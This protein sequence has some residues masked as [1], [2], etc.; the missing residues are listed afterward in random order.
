[1]SGP[2]PTT[3]QTEAYLRL[4]SEHERWLAGYVFSLVPH[5]AD[6]EDILQEVK[7]TMWRQFGR[8]ELGSNFKAWART[9]ATHAVLNYRRAVKKRSHPELEDAFI[10]AVAAET[11]HQADHLEDRGEALQY[12]LAKLPD[13]QRRVISW[14]YFDDCGVDEIAQ[15]AGRSAEAVYQML[16]R[17]RTA[18]NECIERRLAGI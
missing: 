15:K 11:T 18:L 7:L 10:E 13:N 3:E 5:A 1:M 16:S 9:I 2:E 6:G 8:F 14:R 17:I 4:L 12:C